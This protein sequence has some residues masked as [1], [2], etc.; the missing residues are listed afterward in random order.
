MVGKKNIEEICWGE[1]ITELEHPKPTSGSMNGKHRESYASPFP[2]LGLDF[3]FYFQLT[4]TINT[5]II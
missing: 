3:S 1:P 4:N 5:A 2:S